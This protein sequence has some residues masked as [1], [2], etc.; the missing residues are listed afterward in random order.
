MKMLNYSISLSAMGFM[1]RRQSDQ[2][3]FRTFTRRVPLGDQRQSKNLGEI[4]P[5]C[6]RSRNIVVHVRLFLL[7]L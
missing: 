1:Q 6:R 3:A 5:P 2:G 4:R 7:L